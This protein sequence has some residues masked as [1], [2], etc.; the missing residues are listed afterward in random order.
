[1]ASFRTA[2]VIL[3]LIGLLTISSVSAQKLTP[4][5]AGTIGQPS[6]RIAFIKEKGVWIMNADGTGQ[7][8]VCDATN[9]DGRLSWA[10]DGNR[11]AFTRSGTASF[12]GPDGGSGG[13]HKIY[14]IFVAFIDSAKVGNTFFWNM[15]T[16]DVGSRDPEWSA[17][18]S[19]IL[20]WKDMNA[21]YI[22]ATGPN[23]QVCT[24]TPDGK[25]FQM[26]R[27]DWQNMSEFLTYP[28]MSAT[29]LIAFEM[30]I[31][32]KRQG[33]IAVLPKTDMMA[34]LADI[35]AKAAKLKG[36]VAPAWSPD[37][38]WLAIVRNDISK[39]GIYLTTPDLSK[40]YL[41]YEPAAGASVRAEAPSFS[42]DSKWLTFATSDEAVWI[43]DITGNQ[44]KRITSPG[45]GKTPA[46]SKAIKK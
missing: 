17:D 45:G 4:A 44:A 24:M 36:F 42:P 9:A 5:L 7:M 38:K 40:L 20:F 29:G 46:W 11:I 27:K 3:S 8:K 37:G 33:G 35:K 23:Y 30:I 16:S 26:F 18:G 21:N 2:R 22:N 25:N 32:L 14:D 12:Q 6:G 43:C 28:S 39:P 31:D 10:P 13:T 19:T 1:M 34:P 15:L 41:V